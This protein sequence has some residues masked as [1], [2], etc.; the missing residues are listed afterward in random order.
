MDSD[1]WAILKNL[2]FQEKTALATFWATFG[3]IWA[4]FYFNI[5]SH[6]KSLLLSQC[7]IQF[8]QNFQNKVVTKH[9]VF[10]NQDRLKAEASITEAIFDDPELR[11]VQICVIRCV[12]CSKIENSQTGYTF[13]VC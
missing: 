12:K 13:P 11:L 6:W 1:F 7:C 3:K 2:Q 9:W 10:D 5:W 4:T 8:R